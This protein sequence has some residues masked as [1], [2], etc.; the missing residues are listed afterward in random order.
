MHI[1]RRRTRPDCSASGIRGFAGGGGGKG[2]RRLERVQTDIDKTR[3]LV[4]HI[5][6]I[7]PG[8]LVSNDLEKLF[9]L[10]DCSL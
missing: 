5:S 10:E 9:S 4:S 1:V 6:R 3:L 7:I 2:N 8:I